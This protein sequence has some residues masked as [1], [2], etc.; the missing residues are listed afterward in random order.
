LNDTLQTKLLRVIQEKKVLGVGEDQEIPVG[1][2]FIAATNRELDRMVTEGK[3][4]ADLF[5][6]LS[7]LS[8]QIPPIR[9]RPEDLKPLVQH[10]L[11]KHHDVNPAAPDA[12]GPDFIDALQR[13]EL[14]GNCRQLENLILQALV[15]K[16]DN[17]P[18]GLTDLSAEAWQQLS[19]Q[20]TPALG[21]TGQPVD[22]KDICDS[23]LERN[24]AD[25]SSYFVTNHKLSLS[26]YL[27]HCERTFLQ[28]AL[29]AARGNQSQTARL[30][31]ITARSVYSKIRKHNLDH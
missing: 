6:R 16:V 15:N 27:R 23:V 2:R 10:F 26:A 29:K 17:T 24:P 7:V 1:V 25:I 28:A 11:S 8:I 4:R 18:L 12:A 31:G 19:E 22:R 20:A 9:E 21:P 30:L 3:F 14:S 13:L 5:H